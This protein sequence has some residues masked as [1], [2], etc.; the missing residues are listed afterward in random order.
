MTISPNFIHMHSYTGPVFLFLT[1]LHSVEEAPVSPTSLELTQMHSC[2]QLSN[3]PPGP[4][5]CSGYLDYFHVLAI[6][7]SR[8]MNIGV[9]V[10]LS[11]LLSLGCMPGWLLGHTTVLFPCFF[12]KSYGLLW[13]YQ[14]SLLHNNVSWLLFTPSPVFL[15]WA[16]GWWS[17]WPVWDST[18]LWYWLSS[19]W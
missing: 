2:P 7:N 12:K 14:Y 17:L 3:S 9:H 13:L 15:V 11:V 8:G 19:L 1:L 16:F 5:I 18:S 10:P 4:F 6:V